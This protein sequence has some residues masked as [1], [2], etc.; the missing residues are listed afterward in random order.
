MFACPSGKCSGLQ[1]TRFHI[2]IPLEEEFIS[3]SLITQNHENM[4]YSLE[5]PCMGWGIKKLTQIPILV[6]RKNVLI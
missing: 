4:G 5:V 3:W 1:I 6:C 2:Q